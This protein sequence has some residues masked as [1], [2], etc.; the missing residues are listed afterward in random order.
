LR[1]VIVLLLVLGLG[2]FLTLGGGFRRYEEYRVRGAL[3]EAGFSDR[4]AECMA[5]RMVERLDLFQL[6]KL[7]RFPEERHTL[8]AMVR[9]VERVDDREAIAVTASSAALCRLGLAR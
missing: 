9:G 7:Q 3:V 1:K 2:W 5:A 6:M 8:G 4:R